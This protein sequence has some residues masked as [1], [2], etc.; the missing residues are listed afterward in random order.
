MVVARRL[1]SDLLLY[2]HLF[3]FNNAIVAAQMH[4]GKQAEQTIVVGIEV[5]IL[6]GFVLSIPQC[7]NKLLTLLVLTQDRGGCNGTYQTDTMTQLADATSTEN[8][9]TRGQ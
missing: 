6:E 8:F 5:A 3:W 2:S 4:E 7:I 9:V 1:F